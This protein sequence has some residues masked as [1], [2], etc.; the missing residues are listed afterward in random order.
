MTRLFYFLCIFFVASSL[1]CGLWFSPHRVSGFAQTGRFTR[2]KSGGTSQKGA[3]FGYGG[4][5]ERLKNSGFYLYAKAYTD[6]GT[7][8]GSTDSKIKLK[9]R[10]DS[11]EYYGRVGWSFCFQKFIFAPF[12]GGGVSY[13]TN[14]F[15][16]PSPL[17]VSMKINFPY[18]LA[19]LKAEWRQTECLH[20][21]A[22][23]ML[24]KP[25]EPKCKIKDDPDFFTAHQ[26][27]KEKLQAD[28]ELGVR[29]QGTPWLECPLS[30]EAFFFY[31][32][33]HFGKHT[34]YPF[35]FVDTKYR[36]LGL[37]ISASIVF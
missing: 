24:K 15:I 5:Y 3:L 16:D 27:I 7:L 17:H 12:L 18:A 33:N 29:R 9:S 2:T 23:I 6:K 21:I 13:S 31:Q 34:N 32:Y 28:F 37:R 11:E 25:Y 14:R 22:S 20:F 35:N 10:F 8:E 26:M 4:E 1:E 19:G 30:A 36:Y